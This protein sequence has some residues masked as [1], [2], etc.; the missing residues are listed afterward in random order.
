MKKYLLATI[1]LCLAVPA[2]SRAAGPTDITIPT[3]IETAFPGIQSNDSSVHFQ[4][5]GNDFQ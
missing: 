1:G 2:F 5:G 4:R 3:N